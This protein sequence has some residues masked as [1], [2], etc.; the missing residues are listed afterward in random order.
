MMR[1]LVLSVA[2]CMFAVH[3]A[4]CVGQGTRSGLI[5]EQTALRHGLVRSWWTQVE[6]DRTRDR[7]KHVQL[8]GDTLYAQTELSVVQAIDAETGDVKWAR[9]VG[10]RGHFSHPLAATDDYVA[11]VNGGNLFMVDAQTGKARWNLR[12]PGAAMAGP[13]LSR[14]R[15][16]VPLVKGLIYSWQLRDHLDARPW[17]HD[18]NGRLFGQLLSTEKGVSWGTERGY[19]YLNEPRTPDEWFKDKLSGGVSANITYREPYYLVGTTSGYAYAVEENS[20]EHVEIFTHSSPVS[21]PVVAMD[22]HAYVFP[23]NSGMFKTSIETG[24][25]KWWVPQARDFIAC[26]GKRVYVADRLGRTLVID[27]ENGSLIETLPTE[28]MPLKMA[29]HTTDR[30][31]VGTRE[32]L[33][34]CLYEIGQKEP[35]RYD[36]TK[37]AKKEDKPKPGEKEPEDPFAKPENKDPFAVD[38]DPFAADPKDGGKKDEDPFGAGDGGK[39]D[40]PFG[41]GGDDPFGAGGDDDPFGAGG[42]DDPFAAGGDDPFAAGGDDPFK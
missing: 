42:G 19:V 3:A 39:D 9:Q 25:E 24:E 22:K 14:D 13:G 33:I 38:K 2:I 27:K 7:I 36:R 17:T 41:A 34:Q 6:M 37:E 21:R 26:S 10:K 40:D 20:E 30:I 28:R 4:E 23:L 1:S 29:N 15:V 12:L 8:I 11:V 18:A 32:G 31:Y 5:S 35:I 16:Y